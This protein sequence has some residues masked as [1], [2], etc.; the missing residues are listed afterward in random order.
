MAGTFQQ[1]Y[2][3]LQQ[4]PPGRVATYGQIAQLVPGAHARVVSFALALGR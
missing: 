1:I 4:I 2:F 3:I